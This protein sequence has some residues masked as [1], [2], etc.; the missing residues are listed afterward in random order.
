MNNQEKISWLLKMVKDQ[1]NALEERVCNGEESPLN[2]SKKLKELFHQCI[3][4]ERLNDE[5][6]K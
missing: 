5:P 1:I 3:E 4:L 2:T 6:I